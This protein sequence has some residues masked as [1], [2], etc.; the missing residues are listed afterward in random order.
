MLWQTDSCIVVGEGFKEGRA[1]VV[2]LD[3]PGPHAARRP[4]LDR[5]RSG[6]KYF[7]LISRMLKCPRLP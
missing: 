5:K 7:K 2:G 3:A 1:V 4:R 6:I